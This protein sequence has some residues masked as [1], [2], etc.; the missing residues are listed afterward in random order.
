[1]ENLP[2]ELGSTAGKVTECYVGEQTVDL[3]SR[4]ELIAFREYISGRVE[5]LLNYY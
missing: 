3:L 5:G 1:M 2:K 4:E